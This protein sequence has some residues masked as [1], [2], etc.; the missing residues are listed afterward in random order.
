[1][2]TVIA[3]PYVGVRGCDVVLAEVLGEDRLAGPVGLRGEAVLR[4]DGDRP[5][6][7]LL[8]DV[9]WH[10]LRDEFVALDAVDDAAVEV[11]DVLA[12]GDEEVVHLVGRRTRLDVGGD[13]VECLHLLLLLLEAALALDL[14]GDVLGETQ[15]GEHVSIAVAQRRRPHAPVSPVGPD[16]RATDLAVLDGGPEHRFEGGDRVVGVHL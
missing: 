5:V 9:V 13:V 15:P 7:L 1:M 4:V 11:E 16:G 6:V 2:G 14:L 10:R 8:G 3:D 12:G